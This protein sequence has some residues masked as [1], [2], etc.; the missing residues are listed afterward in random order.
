MRERGRK[1]ASGLSNRA[2]TL[3]L[4]VKIRPRGEERTVGMRRADISMA[5][6]SHDCTH[7]VKFRDPPPQVLT[8]H[9][10]HPSPAS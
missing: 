5:Q 4:I 10:T 8:I 1:K 3:G 6:L 2:D 9:T 7:A